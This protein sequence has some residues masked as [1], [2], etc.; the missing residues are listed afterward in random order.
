MNWRGVQR[1]RM[2]RG[3]ALRLR[4][5]GQCQSRRAERERYGGQGDREAPHKTFLVSDRTRRYNEKHC[6]TTTTRSIMDCS[7][8]P[9]D[10]VLPRQLPGATNHAVLDRGELKREATV[11]GR[12]KRKRAAKPIFDVEQ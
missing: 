9:S 8:A 3:R 2:D 7:G 1:L 11:R 4:V 6:S 12:E 5:G 10:G